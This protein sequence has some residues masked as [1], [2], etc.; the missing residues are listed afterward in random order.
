M[1]PWVQELDARLVT[2]EVFE[3]VRAVLEF[4]VLEHT[5]LLTRDAPI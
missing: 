1:S 4:E 3:H 2:E 5:Q